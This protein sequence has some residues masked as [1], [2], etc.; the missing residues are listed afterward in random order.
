MVFERYL[1]VHAQ[2]VRRFLVKNVYQANHTAY[3]PI[4]TEQHWV[5]QTKLDNVLLPSDRYRQMKTPASSLK[6]NEQFNCL[7][8]TQKQY[9]LLMASHSTAVLPRHSEQTL[10]CLTLFKI[11][12]ALLFCPTTFGWSVTSGHFKMV[13]LT[14]L[15]SDTWER[16]F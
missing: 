4:S 1:E 3:S 5:V 6:L 16:A 9:I 2:K 10:E 11:L 15:K 14:W 12:K 7:F 8:R 13:V